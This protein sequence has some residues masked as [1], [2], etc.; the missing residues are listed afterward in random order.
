MT[1]EIKRSKRAY[2]PG[3]M[4]IGLGLEVNHP[5]AVRAAAT[6]ANGDLTGG[7]KCTPPPETPE[8]IARVGSML[9]AIPANCDYEQW[10]NDVWAV[11]AM[12]WNC[13]KELARVW[14]ASASDKFDE[15]AFM[16]VWNSY[17][18]S[19]GI[20]FGTL[21]HHAKRHGWIDDATQA[22]PSEQKQ[23]PEWLEEL[24]E[25]YALIENPPSIYRMEYGNCIDPTKF[26]LQLDNIVIGSGKQQ[27][28]IGTAWL[29]HRDRRQH[30]ELVLRPKEN[31]V[32]HDNCLN[33]WKAYPVVPKQGDVAPFLLLLDI[34][35]PDPDARKFVILWLAHLIQ[36][37]EIKMFVA[38]AFWS[39]EQGVG[40][41]LLFECLSGIIGPSHATVI[42]Q[43]QLSASFNGW[44]N[45]K[46]L[47]IGDEVSGSDRRAESDMLK[48]LVTGTTIHINEKHQPSR[49]VPNFVNF[50][51]LSN[52]NDALFVDDQD[53][54]FFVWEITSGRLPEVM[55]NEFVKWR[56]NGGLSALLDYFLKYDISGF[57]PK[58]PAPMTAAKGQMV[59]DNRSDLE[60]WIAD[61]VES[62]V[63]D[64]LG[65]EVATSYEIATQYHRDRGSHGQPP[66]TKAVGGACKK[67]GAYMRVNQVRNVTGKK[68][69]VM[70]LARVEHWKT[71]PE[72][73]WVEEMR[74]QINA[75]SCL[76]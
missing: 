12:G 67:F 72:S 33:E 41:N 28:G 20:G 40:K 25:K 17:N 13:G 48:G 4:I 60:S 75:R 32:T 70:A 14:S 37:P 38:L 58:A 56:N 18:P 62:N 69:R 50:I 36:H 64:V 3:Q 31:L 23:L 39:L 44:A 16:A 59:A 61:L 29:R 1:A 71:Q 6:A 21:V 11:A 26:K 49:E 5:I 53:R 19:G 8:E 74:K 51:F 35:V 55:A 65:R 24:N 46:V 76:A 15:A 42:G 7:L 10:R 52:H 27:V 63:G 34:L 66:S 22:E 54:R 30:R 68:V 43:A 57:N 73:A 2:T 45:R 47:V 9:K